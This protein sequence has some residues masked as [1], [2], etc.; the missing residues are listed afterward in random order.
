MDL[1][2]NRESDR[3]HKTFWGSPL[4]TGA[5]I[6]H[7]IVQSRGFSIARALGPGDA[8]LPLP[9]F[10]G[11]ATRWWRLDHA[12]RKSASFLFVDH[13]SLDRFAV[14]TPV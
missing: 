5:M 4:I 14:E 13:P 3:F 10:T 12:A 2:N 9:P 11:D 1:R 8:D 7:G 6:K